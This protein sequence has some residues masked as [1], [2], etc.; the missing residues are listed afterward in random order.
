MD[1]FQNQHNIFPKGEKTSAD[2]FTGTSWLNLLVAK[3]ETEKYA[4]GN[5]EFEAGS[6]TNWHTHPAGQILL[7]TQGKGIYQEKDKAPRQL[8]KGDVVIIPSHIEHWHG[9]TNESSFTHIAVT[10]IIEKVNVEWLT[11]VSEE[12]YL[13]CQ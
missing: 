7:V 6:R 10:N 12:E 1:T 5:V 9:A 11:P 8:N 4:I 2:Y 13:A 3:D